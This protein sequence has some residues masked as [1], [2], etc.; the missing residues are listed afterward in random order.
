MQGEGQ[1]IQAPSMGT[2]RRQNY[3]TNS[4]LAEQLGECSA[5]EY[6]PSRPELLRNYEINIQFLSI[7]CTIRVGCKTIPFSSTEEAMKELA[8]YVANPYDT[9]KKWDNIFAE[10]K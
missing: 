10:Y 2:E 8:E 9:C 4:P 5:K 7:G 1:T 6:R 3:P